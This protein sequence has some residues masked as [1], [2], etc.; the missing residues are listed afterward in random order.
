MTLI[1][2]VTSKNIKIVDRSVKKHRFQ[3][4]QGARNLLGSRRSHRLSRVEHGV[5]LRCRLQPFDC[6]ATCCALMLQIFA[7]SCSGLVKL[8]QL[9]IKSRKST[10]LGST[11]LQN[12][13]LLSSFEALRHHLGRPLS[14]DLRG[15]QLAAVQ[16]REIF[17][18]GQQELRVRGRRGRPALAQD[19][20]QVI[21]ARQGVVAPEGLEVEV[22]AGA[23]V[24][25]AC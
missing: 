6:W 22:A 9:P 8:L 14:I 10:T 5:H 20:A 7:F 23:Q 25:Q 24:L 3:C 13:P 19:V 17:V 4:L 12:A 2:F 11:P 18:N 16:Q 1:A 21:A 15:D